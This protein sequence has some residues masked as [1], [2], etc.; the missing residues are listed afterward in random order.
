MDIGLSK[1]RSHK[2]HGRYAQHKTPSNW[3]LRSDRHDQGGIHCTATVEEGSSDPA[4]TE[5]HLRAETFGA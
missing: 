1:S 3:N 4:G 2:N 5:I